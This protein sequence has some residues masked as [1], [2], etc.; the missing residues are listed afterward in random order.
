MKTIV[1]IFAFLIVGFTAFCDVP[2]VPSLAE[3]VREVDFIAFISITNVTTTNTS[4]QEGTV[5]IGIGTIERILMGSRHPDDLK[6]RQ[7]VIGPESYL[8]TLEKGRYLIFAKRSGI[9][10]CPFG[11]YGLA[12]VF[13]TGLD[14]DRVLW[15]NCESVAEVVGRI[16]KE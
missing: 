12:P 9:S 2:P 14:T 4:G 3:R 5:F 1:A 13:G 15:P 8:A 11:Y 10:I 7:R 6:V 16:E